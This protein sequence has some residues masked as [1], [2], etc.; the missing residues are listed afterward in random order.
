MQY[1]NFDHTKYVTH[2]K[3]N[4]NQSGSA[5]LSNARVVLFSIRTGAIEVYNYSIRASRKQKTLGARLSNSFVKCLEISPTALHRITRCKKLPDQPESNF[6]RHSTCLEFLVDCSSDALHVLR[7]PVTNW[8]N[9]R[10]V[11][12]NGKYGHY[13]YVLKTVD[14]N[15]LL[16]NFS[17]CQKTFENN[18]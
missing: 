13:I 5:L 14:I 4:H 17:C 9:H 6:T 12:R 3:S 7:A 11:G 15:N 1:I 18:Y 16:V 8:Q 10:S 2:S